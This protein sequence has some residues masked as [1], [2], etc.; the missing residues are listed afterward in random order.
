MSRAVQYVRFGEE[1]WLSTTPELDPHV[2]DLGELFDVLRRRK[3]TVA[4]VTLL[5]TGLALALVYF[6]ER[7]VTRRKR[8]SPCSHYRRVRL[9]KA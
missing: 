7:P 3:G 4:V 2:I 5:F 8:R 6:S 9:S 1:Q